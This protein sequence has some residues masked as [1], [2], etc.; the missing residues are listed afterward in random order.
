MNIGFY[1]YQHGY[2][3]FVVYSSIACSACEK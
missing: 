2:K 1:V 3:S